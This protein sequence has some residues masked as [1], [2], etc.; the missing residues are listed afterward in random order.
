MSNIRYVCMSDMHLG[1]E[2]SL[3]TNLETASTKTDPTSPS[4]V[5]QW[6]ANRLRDL[7]YANEN[8]KKPTLILCGDILEMAL[9]TTNEAAMV[10]ERFIELTMPKGDELFEAIIYIPGNHDHHL[11]ESARETQYANY[12]SSKIKPADKLPVAWHTTN[13]FVENEADRVPSYFLTSLV[14]RHGHLKKLNIT[15]AYPNFGLI[16]EDGK[17]SVIFHHGHYIEKLY[18]LFCIW[19][20][21]RRQ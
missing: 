19:Y 14:Q 17:K 18:Y 13:I 2:D 15:V 6:L 4:P 20:N 21:E 12:I 10:F 7:I 8:K 1:E 5:M 11:W 9:T 16:K 3:L